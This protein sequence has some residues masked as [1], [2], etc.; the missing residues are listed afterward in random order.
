MSRKIAQG[1]LEWNASLVRVPM[2]TQCKALLDAS[3]CCALGCV[4]CCAVCGNN[5]LTVQV[6]ISPEL[7]LVPMKEVD[8]QLAS[9]FEH[10]CGCDSA[11]A[12]VCTCATRGLAELSFSKGGDLGSQ[13]VPV[14]GKP[15]EPCCSKLDQ[16]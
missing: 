4:S 13:A 5:A 15:Y 14:G 12:C 8:N 6:L 7:A 9:K 2:N 11:Y 10:M 1:A 16:V 3:H